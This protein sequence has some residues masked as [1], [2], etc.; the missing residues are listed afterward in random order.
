MLKVQPNDIIKFT[1]NGNEIVGMI[2]L[3]NTS[4]NFITYKVFSNRYSIILDDSV[5]LIV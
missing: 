2:N 4:K 1:K 5:Q 3:T